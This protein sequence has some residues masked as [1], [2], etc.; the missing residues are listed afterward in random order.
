MLLRQLMS[1]EQ[2]RSDRLR[3]G[4]EV[5]AAHDVDRDRA[6]R[7]SRAAT[8]HRPYSSQTADRSTACKLNATFSSPMM[9]E[10]ASPSRRATRSQPHTSPF[11]SKPSFDLRSA[12]HLSTPP[13]TI[14]RIAA[15]PFDHRSLTMEDASLFTL[16]VNQVK[17]T[18]SMKQATPPNQRTP[19]W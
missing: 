15:N 2:L 6:C 7:P 3:N 17:S 4:S 13:L 10:I 1:A 11:T 19:L 5:S 8:P 9:T 18:T 14:E 12:R 16:I